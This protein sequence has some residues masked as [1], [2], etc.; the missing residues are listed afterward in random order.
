MAQGSESSMS[1]GA[2]GHC[3]SSRAERKIAD[4]LITIPVGRD[5]RYSGHPSAAGGR[6]R[7][8]IP[9]AAKPAWPGDCGSLGERGCTSLDEGSALV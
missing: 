1:V 8:R 2:F 6:T 7:R 3:T 5:G 9:E 4:D